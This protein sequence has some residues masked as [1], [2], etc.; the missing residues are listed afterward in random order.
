MATHA[1]GS[2]TIAAA[3]SAFDAASTD[4]LDNIFG[5]GD[6]P[7]FTLND[8]QATT[9]KF[10]VDELPTRIRTGSAHS[11]TAHDPFSGSISV[12][13]FKVD[14]AAQ[15]SRLLL[16][17]D[18]AAWGLNG[19]QG[20]ALVVTDVTG[21]T[22]KVEFDTQG[23]HVT[24]SPGSIIGTSGSFT[25]KNYVVKYADD[26][27]MLHFKTNSQS[28]TTSNLLLYWAMKDAFDNGFGVEPFQ[29]TNNN[30]TTN[31]PNAGSSSGTALGVL[32]QSTTHGYLGNICKVSVSGSGNGTFTSTT[33]KELA[34]GGYLAPYPNMTEANLPTVHGGDKYFRGGTIGGGEGS[35][36]TTEIAQA[37]V[38]I[39]NGTAGNPLL[40]M[41]AARS[42]AVANI[43]A[44]TAGTD[45]NQTI[46][47]ANNTDLFTISGMSG[48]AATSAAGRS[49]VMARTRIKGRQIAVGGVQRSNIDSGSVEI[50]HLNFLASEGAASWGGALADGDIIPVHDT[51][52][53]TVRGIELIDL[54]SYLSA[55]VITNL[56]ASGD[57]LLGDATGDTVNV[58]GRII[59][60]LIPK[61]HNN[62]K[63]FNTK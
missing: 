35:L 18:V 27:Y 41:T 8:G 55:S 31:Q 52:A 29:L 22:V 26:H 28:N 47:A 61:T 63:V 36:A 42:S 3:G 11:S 6:T 25:A 5:T 13:T 56:T 15:R 17:S 37:I 4:N 1:S 10:I 54:K 51:S 45:G 40:D 39:V 43:T 2:V 7:E 32:L 9:L 14:G 57:V 44:G 49:N 58:V 19:H 46:T 21:S 38:D 20:L 60:S 23:N 62:T 59:S 48:G 34:V 12:P 50:G 53:D 33:K 30:G 24:G 16:K